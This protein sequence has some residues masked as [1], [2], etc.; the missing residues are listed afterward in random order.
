M[1][2]YNKIEGGDVADIS[3]LHRRFIEKIE[4][5]VEIRQV[6]PQNREGIGDLGKEYRTTIDFAFKIEPESGHNSSVYLKDQSVSTSKLRL[7]MLNTDEHSM[8]SVLNGIESEVFNGEMPEGVGSYEG[9][10]NRPL[11]EYPHEIWKCP[12][13]KIVSNGSPVEDVAEWIIDLQMKYS[14][15]R[16]RAE[17]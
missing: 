2:E 17:R 7:G 3:P 10:V 16:E 14:S 9:V 1:V 11:E 8:E 12:H 6:F 15:I 4:D 13:V 5:W